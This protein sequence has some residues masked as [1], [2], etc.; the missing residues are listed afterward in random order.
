MR[1]AGR[2]SP[3][4]SQARTAVRALLAKP[5]PPPPSQASPTCREEPLLAPRL[6]TMPLQTVSQG[7]CD[8]RPPRG[9][10]GKPQSWERSCAH[11]P[12]GDGD[13]SRG[14]GA[15]GHA[16]GPR[17]RPRGRG[18]KAHGLAEGQGAGPGA[19]RP[20]RPG[21]R[22]VRSSQVVP[23]ETAGR[24][25]RRMSRTPRARPHPHYP[26]CSLLGASR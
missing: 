23:P 24:R 16:P 5:G 13:G 9:A 19:A 20:A 26:Q 6:R 22:D 12:E 1:E 7:P 25:R 4:R 2:P 8:V 21:S 18:R 14:P 11:R 10:P 17:L 15:L 3:L